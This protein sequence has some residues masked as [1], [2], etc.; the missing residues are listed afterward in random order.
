MADVQLEMRQ[1]DE[2]DKGRKEGRQLAEGVD[3]EQQKEQTLLQW[4]QQW[5]KDN[6]VQTLPS[7]SSID[8]ND[9]KARGL[10]LWI[11]A[12]H[13]ALYL[14]VGLY[15]ISTV[16][17]REYGRMFLSLTA[18]V[19]S[20]CE[21]IPVA[22]TGT[23]LA[24]KSGVWETSKAFDAANPL[25]QLTLTGTKVTEEQYTRVMQSFT[26]QLQAYGDKTASL[27]TLGSQIAWSLF[28]TRDANSVM[29]LTTTA[30]LGQIFV[31]IDTRGIIPVFS[32]EE[33]VCQNP[34]LSRPSFNPSTLLLTVTVPDYAPPSPVPS[35]APSP[36][37]GQA[38]S[39][40]PTL[41]HAPTPRTSPAA[42]STGGPIPAPTPRP[43]VQT[44]VYEFCPDQVSVANSTFDLNSSL[45]HSFNV[46]LVSKVT[47]FALNFGIID[48]TSLTKTFS[49][50]WDLG[51]DV[52]VVHKQG[53]FDENYP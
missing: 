29:T 9:L 47:A 17:S 10:A 20:V 30:Q 23:Y 11:A 36:Q 22:V 27:D 38:P 15:F 51:G 49:D 35:P 46:D 14:T 28:R 18:D 1:L 26:A 2:Q 3:S 32:S 34:L 16:T 52:G 42:P 6:F 13:L 31:S 50:T 24:D 37:P 53:W 25:Y 44:E 8:V 39:P 12:A 21:K 45:T 40:G 4:L 19:S 5:A 43:R 41:T 7:F 48:T 33:G